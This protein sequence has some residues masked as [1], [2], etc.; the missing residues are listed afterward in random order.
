[1]TPLAD[2]YVL[3][4]I[5][6]Q[7]PDIWS[8]IN[9]RLVSLDVP[10]LPINEICAFISSCQPYILLVKLLKNASS[11]GERLTCSI[12]SSV[13]FSP[14]VLSHSRYDPNRGYFWEFPEEKS[15][16]EAKET[17][18]SQH[19]EEPTDLQRRRVD[20]LLNDLIKKFP[21]KAFAKKVG[22]IFYH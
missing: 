17:P 10:I 8:I 1:M 18:V 5:V 19:P 22:E 16:Q 12:H 14:P 15:S 2:Y 4:G 13:P 21:P 3:G 9:S 7:C 11:L 20:N 6:Y